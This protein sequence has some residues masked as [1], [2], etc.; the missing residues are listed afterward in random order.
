[1]LLFLPGL[2][3]DARV[4]APQCAAFPDSHAVDGY[5][6]ADS[7]EAMARIALEQAPER[8]DLFGH[9]MGGRVALEVFRLAPQRVRRLALSST[10]VHSLGADEPAKREALQAIGHAQ[11]YEAQVDAWLPPMVG[12]HNR[13][14]AALYGPMRQMCLDQSQAI[15]DAQ[16]AALLGRR[17]QE[18]LL[19]RIACPALV[20]TGALDTWSGPERHRTIAAAIPDSTVTIVE[21][22]GHMLPLEAPAAVNQAIADWLSRPASD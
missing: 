14:N 19:P 9:S 22:A 16:I 1:M 12:D 8:F 5:G 15:F 7:L 3:C 20:M 11:G 17:E 10:G 13:A 4:F 21:G 6:T 2:I 18:S